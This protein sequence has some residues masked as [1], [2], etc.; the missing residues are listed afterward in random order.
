VRFA[1]LNGPGQG[2]D[3]DNWRAAIKAL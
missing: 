3:A 1:E 2:R